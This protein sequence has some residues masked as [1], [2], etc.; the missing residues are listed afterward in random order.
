MGIEAAIIGALVATSI[1]VGS[2]SAAGSFDPKMPDPNAA[3]KA[4]ELARKKKKEEL[5]SRRG[6]GASIVT[7]GA[8]LTD[9]QTSQLG[10]SSLLG[11]A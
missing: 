3:K 8:G 9:G 10:Q 1:G 2:A 7:G 6:R 4:E 5:Q 11:T